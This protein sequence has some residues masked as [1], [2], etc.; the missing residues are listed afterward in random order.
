MSPPQAPAGALPVPATATPATTDWKIESW[1][2]SQGGVAAALTATLL[3]GEQPTN[4]LEFAC[5][6]LPI[7][8][9]AL[10]KRLLQGGALDALAACLAPALAKLRQAPMATAAQLTEK[11]VTHGTGF[12]LELGDL[13]MFYGGLGAVIG[14]PNPN[15]LSGMR[16]EHTGAADAT[17]P[18]LM[19][20][21]KA[22]TTSEIEWQFVV[23]PGKALRLDAS[24]TGL[25]M[26]QFEPYPPKNPRKPQPFE[27][28]Q[29][30]F[31]QVNGRLVALG[32]PEVIKEE[33]LATRLYSGP[34]YLK[35][36]AVLRGLQH[37]FMRNAMVSLCCSKEVAD[38]YEAGT[39]T[40]EEARATMNKYTTTLHAINSAVIK[41]AKLTT[42]KPVYRGVS[43]GRLPKSCLEPNQFGIKGG[44]EAGFTSTTLDRGTA[45]FY[46]R[47]GADLSKR[48]G[49]AVIFEVQQGMTS[50]GADIGWLSQ[51]PHEVEILFA[52]LT[53]MEVMSTEVD[54]TTLIVR[55]SLSVNLMARTLEQVIAQLQGS[56][57]EL[58]RMFKGEFS[59]SGVPDEQLAGVEQL[60]EKGEAQ[61][62]WWFNDAENFKA[63]TAQAF[64]ARD[65]VLRWMLEGTRLQAPWPKR[66]AALGTTVDEAAMQ[67]VAEL[68]EEERVRVGTVVAATKDNGVN[69]RFGSA[70]TA[71]D[72]DTITVKTSS[73]NELEGLPPTKALVMC[74]GGA[75][76]LLREAAAAGKEKMVEALLGAG[77]SLFA[78][79]AR[80]NTALHLAAAAGHARVCRML[81]DKGADFTVYNAQKQ[82]ALEMAIANKHE[83]ARRLFQP[84]PSDREFTEEACAATARLR[85]ATTG[86]VA[87][88]AATAAREGE[89]G[90]I[91]ALMV[92]SRAKQLAAVEA[93]I[94]TASAA[95]ID[96]QSAEGCTAL[97]L[98]AEEGDERIVAALL[99][100][101]ASVALIDVDGL[102]ALMR[103]CFLG[104]APCTELLVDKLDAATPE[105]WRALMWACQKGHADCARLLVD[106]GVKVNEADYFGCTALM[107]ACEN[108]HADCVRL[109]VDNSGAKVDAAKSNGFTALMMACQNGHA[110]CARLLVDRG[111]KVDAATSNGGTALMV[112]CHNSHV[113]CARLL[114][115]TMH[116]PVDNCFIS[117][118][119][120][121]GLPGATLQGKIYYELTLTLIG[122]FPQIGWATSGFAPDNR[123]RNGVG[124]DASSWGADGKRGRMWHNN[125]KEDW[126]I[127][128]V[129]GDTIGCAADLQ[130]GQIW[131][132][133][134]GVWTLAFE[135]CSSKWGAGLYPAITGM[136]MS[137]TINS[138]PRY[139]GPTSEFQNIGRLPLQL[140][141]ENYTGFLLGDVQ[142]S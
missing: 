16:F 93:L 1:L 45:E 117:S 30:E 27:E 14:P 75:G 99:T 66:L 86:D 142:R 56:H 28:F 94:E 107:R 41:L 17:E 57:L 52:P 29:R 69:W 11:F 47:G 122:P 54:G 141:D 85:A 92:A 105:V 134:N 23:E 55:V 64:A 100:R 131:F 42:A 102:S 120:T 118:F 5:T 53:G 125:G 83:A 46:A 128:W 22:H 82:S 20:N 135:G 37:T 103:A 113:N 38:K 13:S 119:G 87:A 95:T 110:D 65:V 129:D 112:A 77:V 48:D 7:D 8:E 21:Q 12:D 96:A 49:P 88:L 15:V 91:T 34:M 116:L 39:M 136:C 124:D 36:N 2:Q 31:D 25:L 90:K 115:D 67:M 81:R 33:F 89:E 32:E 40:F 123:N 72:S 104:H 63:V 71:V 59:A 84:T 9:A 58:L 51:F 97:H 138:M 80:L 44:V 61:K 140:C 62:G 10:K 74:E 108:G 78:A 73:D 70:V 98:A 121:A 133:H 18:F 114:L 137:F 106:K 127:R 111:T 35:F 139:A 132:G 101:S 3:S 26:D 50:R 109:L 130:G 19:P 6:Q 79:D 24:R 60:M 43:G 68:V 76:A 4:E 126:D